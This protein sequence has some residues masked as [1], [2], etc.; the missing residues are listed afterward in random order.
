[1]G[2]SGAHTIIYADDA[3]AARAFFRDVLG[4]PAVDDG[5]G[6]L[7]FALPPGELAVHPGVSGTHSLYLMCDDL[8]A[9]MA[10]LAGKGVALGP[11]H[12]ERWGRVTAIA[13]PGA[14][15]VGLYQPLHPQP[16]R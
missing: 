7:I 14:G 3:E 15:D 12:E 10:E 8:D 9:T 16:P 1:M 5:G 11:V 4:F 2:I 13:V 6:W